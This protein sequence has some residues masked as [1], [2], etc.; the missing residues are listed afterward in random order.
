[1]NVVGELKWYLDDTYAQL[2]FSESK[3]A[4]HIDTIMVPAAH[5][6]KEIGTQLINHVLILADAMKK[7]VKVSA[8]PFANFTE[9]KLQRLISYYERFGFRMEDRTH[10]IAYLVRDVQD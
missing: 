10:S 4:L 2:K 6:S 9:E 1:M 8:R 3:N 7:E 5:R